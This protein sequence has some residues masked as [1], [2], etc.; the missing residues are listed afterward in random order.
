MDGIR[1]I[2]HNAIDM[3][4]WD[5]CISRSSRPLVYA[6]STYLNAIC[7]HSWDALVCGNYE[8][9]FPLPVKRKWGVPMVYQ[10]F[11]CQQLGLFA[12][13]DF[14]LGY[15]D[16]LKAIP[17][18]FLKV[19]LQLNPS[20][21]L[22]D[23]IG[24]RCN[25]LLD[26]NRSYEVIHDA[27]NADARKNLR[28]CSDAEILV[29]PCGDIHAAVSLYKQVWGKLNPVIK[30][31][32]YRNFE[33]ACLA[34][35]SSSEA[36]CFKAYIDD[37]VLAYAIFLRSPNYLHYVCAAPTAE[38]RKLG[39][40]H[41]VIDCIAKTHSAQNLYLDF[42]GSEIPEVAAFYRKFGPLEESYG[43]FHRSVMHY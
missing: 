30:D 26:L 31:Q 18:K 41:A 14:A 29:E 11:F 8:A 24:K 20:F 39:V 6:G 22:P 35:Q 10:P 5:A 15:S 17:R 33:N 32:H 7:N 4:A 3:A 38:G 28:K 21:T 9:V 2:R 43:T 13:K 16:F 12:P 37:K 19:T 40:M 27:Y 23:G 1:Y 25:M 36:I 42:E 34:L